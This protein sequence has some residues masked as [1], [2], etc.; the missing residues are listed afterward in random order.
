MRNAGERIPVNHHRTGVGLVEDEGV[1]AADRAVVGG[2]VDEEDVA[3]LPVESEA[4]ADD[5]VDRGIGEGEPG[6]DVAEGVV[7][8]AAD[9][10]DE[11]EGS[12]A[13]PLGDGGDGVELGVAGGDAAFSKLR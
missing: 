13:G 4:V 9:R 11:V 12:R 7:F 6:V 8:A 5:G 1:D 10:A 3:E 2:F